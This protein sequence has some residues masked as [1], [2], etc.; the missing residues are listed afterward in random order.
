MGE[1]TLK[2]V[3]VKWKEGDILQIP[4]EE[5]L[6]NPHYGIVTSE[7]KAIIAWNSGREGYNKVTRSEIPQNASIVSNPKYFIHKVNLETFF[8]MAII[9]LGEKELI[10]L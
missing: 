8:K 2:R 4:N 10:K 5:P 1:I 7:V 6:L 9:M 3:E